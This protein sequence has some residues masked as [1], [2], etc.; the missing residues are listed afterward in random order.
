MTVLIERSLRLPDLEYGVGNG[1]AI[2]C[3]GA[4]SYGWAYLLHRGHLR[5]RRALF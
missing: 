4:Q 1:R 5:L 3:P 2:Q